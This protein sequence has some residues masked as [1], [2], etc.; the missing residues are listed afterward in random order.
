M[1]VC[2]KLSRIFLSPPAAV[3]VVFFTLRKYWANQ[4]F[5][6]VN[7]ANKS[8]GLV[9]TIFFLE[10]N[11][12]ENIENATITKKNLITDNIFRFL[13]IILYLT[14]SAVGLLSLCDVKLDSFRNI[15]KKKNLSLLL[16]L[17]FTV[18]VIVVVVVA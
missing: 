3:F 15:L 9:F 1:F 8:Y 2:Y 11:K 12:F 14:K 7:T 18:V 13:I 4:L 10:Q 5:K 17:F 16:F 6:L